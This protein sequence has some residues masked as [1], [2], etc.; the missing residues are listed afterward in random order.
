MR[1][2]VSPTLVGRQGEQQHL[3]A[4]VEGA[5]QG[6]G[7]VVAVSGP[8]GIGKTRLVTAIAERA[9]G[10]GARVLL[11][12]AVPSRVPAPYRPIGEALLE[13]S[14]SELAVDAPALRGFRAA[15][16]R[17][18]PDWRSGAPAAADES[19]VVV[20]EALLR[21]LRTLAG[22]TACVLL[23]EDLQWADPETLQ[24]VEYLADHL[25][26]LP[27]LCLATA[28][29]E[30]GAAALE[31][32]GRLEARGAID[33]I[34]LEP[35]APAEVAALASQCLEGAPLPDD[36]ERFLRA[37]AEGVPFLVEELLASA[38]AD[39][40]LVASERGWQVAG[41]L[42]PS[43]PRTFGESVR[44]RLA[45]LGPEGRS[46]LGI[47]AALGRRFDWQ[48]V[49]RA[50]G[51][52]PA[53][54]SATLE[55]AAGLQLLV[56]EDD[57]FTFRHAL[58][59]EAVLRLLLP[60]ERAMLAGEALAA[61]ERTPPGGEDWRHL[62][63][64]LAE[65]AGDGD[66]AAGLLLAAGRAALAR[67]ALSTATTALERA[68]R[69]A[70]NLPLRADVQQSLA[71]ARSAAGDLAG[72][73]AA[74]A[75]LL[76]TLD[77]VG[78][79]PRRRAQAHLLVAR[80]AVT[81]T[82]FEVASEELA[83]ARR[84]ASLAGDRPLSAQVAA[85]AAQLAIGEGR[86]DEAEALAT[87]VVDAATA[88]HQPEVVCEA[89]EV[90]GRCARTRDL[91]EAGRLFARGAQVADDAGLA[92]WRMRALYQL[93]T[94]DL[95]SSGD[96]QRLERAREL[97]E[98]LGAVA[99]MA[100]LDLEIGAGLEMQHRPEAALEAF[101]R[102]A[103][104][105][106]VLGLRLLEAMA[107]TFVAVVEA[108][109]GARQRMEAAAR[110]SI[111]LSDDDPEV[112]AGVWSDA[113]AIASL[114]EEDHP[115]ARRELEQAM[116]RIA[117]RPPVSPRPGVAL[118][119]LLAALDG[120]PLDFP[121]LAASAGLVCQGRG[122]LEYARAVACG[123]AGRREDANAAARAGEALL[124]GAPWYRSL[125]RRLSAEAAIADGWGD[126]GTWLREAAAYF[127]S[128][129]SNRLASACRALMR[130]TGARVPR[131]TRATATLPAGLREA[132][133][134]VREAEVLALVGDGLS[135]ADIARR[136]VLSE[137]TVEH[138]IGWLRRKLG[139][140]TRAQMVAYAVGGRRTDELGA[141][142][143]K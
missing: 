102:C 62:A 126:P 29:D 58:T 87:R 32:L 23:I 14:R 64:D 125:M 68:A 26:D 4:R 98:R 57:G 46:I 76:D 49:A 133:V 106:H 50:A 45:E 78:A 84:L 113:R 34:Q 136:L 55:R 79:D 15:L 66:R 137:R 143:V 12:R 54:V 40:G 51:A 75:V 90:A 103:D 19:P 121:A 141:T 11:G 5:L 24:V 74:A 33:L 52:A 110:R 115:R 109:R 53:Q 27:I 43:V 35:L 104:L 69:L 138:H 73:R 18:V 37:G 48:L 82:R 21:V 59:R 63:A 72:T 13:A 47:A 8:A 92:L 44:E 2:M 80:S 142:A 130:R 114:V 60:S 140:E 124:A 131:P 88:T 10:L 70:G 107:Y 97:A 1:R 91:A 105:A 129:G 17:L 9:E 61:L 96:V 101:G 38:V 83:H 128:T 122:Y 20:A 95:L 6:H 123:R 36:F 22:P 28:R 117:G 86:I 134:T 81:A 41:P 39:G 119:A 116:A 30:P 108:T 42:R 67:G 99:T 77:A 135:N 100:S 132:G 31:L 7:G 89:L 71:D 56:A 127:E 112:A 94:V 3:G 139:L 16:G 111:A 25:H 85:V 120:R 65:M 93:G 118:W